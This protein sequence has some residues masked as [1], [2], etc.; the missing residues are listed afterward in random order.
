ME[1]DGA[2]CRIFINAVMMRSLLRGRS[3]LS[4]DDGGLMLGVTS[5]IDLS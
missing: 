1:V 4:Q 5:I 3:T 2:G